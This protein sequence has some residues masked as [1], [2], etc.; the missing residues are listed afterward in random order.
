MDSTEGFLLRHDVPAIAE[1]SCRNH[2]I[3][4]GMYQVESEDLEI[5]LVPGKSTLS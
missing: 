4:D 3:S 2:P 1:E 5:K